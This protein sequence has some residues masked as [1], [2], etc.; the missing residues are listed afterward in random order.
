MDGSPRA[1]C[2]FILALSQMGS[3]E[4]IK[5]LILFDNLCVTERR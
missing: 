5:S 1:D 2:R 3:P 4:A